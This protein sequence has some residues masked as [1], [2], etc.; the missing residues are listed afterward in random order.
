[1]TPLQTADGQRTSFGELRGRWLLVDFIYTRCLTYCSVQGSEFARLQQELAGP[2]A[3]DK[4][5]L[6]SISFDPARDDPTALADYQRR[7]GDRGT[8]WIAA[9]PVDRAGLAELLH[10]FGVVAVP[11]G[12]GGFVHNA[13]I[14]VVDPGGRIVAILDWNDWQAAAGYVRR[15]LRS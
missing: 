5:A 9:R 4:V 11:D 14:A 1:S 6:L 10:R 7:H 2:I 13:A 8:G 15:S 3:A 12:I